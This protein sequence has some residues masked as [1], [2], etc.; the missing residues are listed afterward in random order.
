MKKL[1]NQIVVNQLAKSLL[2][3]RLI[4]IENGYEENT[5]TQLINAILMKIM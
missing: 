1:A 4:L 5:T 3:K 2:I